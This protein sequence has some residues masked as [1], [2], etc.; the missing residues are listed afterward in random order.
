M[1][2]GAFG[3]AGDPGTGPDIFRGESWSLQL[4][5]CRLLFSLRFILLPTPN[6]VLSTPGALR[7]WPGALLGADQHNPCLASACRRAMVLAGLFLCP[8]A[9]PRDSP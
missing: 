9:C 3:Q 4:T 8:Q 2:A 7:G 1:W 6:Q 5:C